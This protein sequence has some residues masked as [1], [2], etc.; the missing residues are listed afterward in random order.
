M[1]YFLIGLGVFF[2]LSAIFISSLVGT[3][4][5]LINSRANVIEAQAQVETQQQRRFDLVPQL[6]GAVRGTLKQEQVVFK[7]IADARTKYAGTSSGSSERVEATNQY[8][9]ALARLMVVIENYPE[10]KSNERVADLMVSI[11]GTE[12]RISVARQRYNE[13]ATIYNKEIKQFPTMIFAAM[14]GFQEQ[15][16]FAGQ[17]GSE[18]APEVN[19]EL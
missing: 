1:K 19:L 13:I 14:F 17:A 2:I 12:N 15:K 9:S 3:Y 4:N 16:L 5:G 6:V 10:L 18:N 11:E 7:A 8:E